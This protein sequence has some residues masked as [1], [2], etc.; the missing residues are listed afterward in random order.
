MVKTNLKDTYLGVTVPKALQNEV[1]KCRK[2]YSFRETHIMFNKSVNEFYTQLL[3]KIDAIPQDFSF[4]LDIDANFF[5]KIS[6][7]IRELF[8]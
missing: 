8:I 4:P 7:N 1:F 6:P 3:F 2:M 5:N